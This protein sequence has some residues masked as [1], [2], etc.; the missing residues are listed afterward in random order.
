MKVWRAFFLVAAVII[1]LQG[2]AGSMKG[3]IR[4]DAKRIELT[5]TDSR[6]GTANLQTILPDGERFEGKTERIGAVDTPSDTTT[7][8]S[9]SA[10]FGDVNLFDGN[11]KATLLG[12][13]GNVMKCR[14]HIADFII[15]LSSGGFGICQDTRGRV[16][17]IFF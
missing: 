9:G 14:F 7:G 11:A 6:I 17:D 15:G 5:Y 1:V 13:R 4:S 2:C 10:D 3:V 12:D 8:G 16:I